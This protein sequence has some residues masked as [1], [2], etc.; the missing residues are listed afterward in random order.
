MSQDKQPKSNTL[1][2][3]I[4]VPGPAIH[5]RDAITV[6][7]QGIGSFKRKDWELTGFIR[8]RDDFKAQPPVDRRA[9]ASRRFVRFRLFLLFQTMTT[10][11][12]RKEPPVN[13]RLGFE[14]APNWLHNRYL[15]RIQH[16]CIFKQRFWYMCQPRSFQF[17]IF[18]Q[19]KKIEN[20]FNSFFSKNVSILE[21]IK[22]LK[23]KQNKT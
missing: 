11:R 20:V 6:T 17:S 9:G 21:Q 12:N 4:Y 10:A 2:M 15:Q 16:R 5:K 13:R 18:K 8:V 14:V 1:S 19:K 3:F 23:T 22:Y 7:R